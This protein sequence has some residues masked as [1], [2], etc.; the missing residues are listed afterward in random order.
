MALP[1]KTLT[2]RLVLN[3]KTLAAWRLFESGV[4]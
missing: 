3:G 2:W 4:N 1:Q